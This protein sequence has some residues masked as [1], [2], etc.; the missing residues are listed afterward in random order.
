MEIRQ[1]FKNELLKGNTV[2]VDKRILTHSLDINLP[3]D[4]FFWIYSIVT[5]V[6]ILIRIVCLFALAVRPQLSF[7]KDVKGSN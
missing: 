2:I 1:R 5:F 6:C 7:N 3:L 4:D